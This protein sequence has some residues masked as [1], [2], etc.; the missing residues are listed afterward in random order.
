MF[1]RFFEIGRGIELTEENDI[2]IPYAK[3]VKGQSSID[4]C[5][6]IATWSNVEVMKNISVNMYLILKNLG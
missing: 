1:V 6:K 5:C 4:G 3:V 2:W